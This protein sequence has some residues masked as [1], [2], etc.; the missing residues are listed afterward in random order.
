MRAGEARTLGE[1]C[2]K[3]SSLNQPM[4]GIHVFGNTDLGT[5]DKVDWLIH[6][7]SATI[8]EATT[9]EVKRNH[10]DVSKTLVA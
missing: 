9:F 7:H 1:H 3:R 8:F 5:K 4:G 10:R 2:L 6:A